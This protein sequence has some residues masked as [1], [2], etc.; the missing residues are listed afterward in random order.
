MKQQATKKRECVLLIDENNT[1]RA[2]LAS[3][4]RTSGHLVLEANT[5]QEA[6]TILQKQEVKLVIWDDAGSKAKNASFLQEVKARQPGVDLI[7]TGYGSR[8]DSSLGVVP[9]AGV[10]N[11][12]GRR[13]ELALIWKTLEQLAQGTTLQEME[14]LLQQLSRGTVFLHQKKLSPPTD[15]KAKGGALLALAKEQEAQPEERLLQ[16]GSFAAAPQSGEAWRGDEEIQLT[17]IEFALWVVLLRHP[18][19]TVSH[20]KLAREAKAFLGNKNS[21]PCRWEAQEFT[22]HYVRKLRKKLEP[23]PSNPRFILSIHG[24]GYRLALPPSSP[25][26]S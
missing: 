24:R 7:I 2:S 13:C 14:Q 5:P 19:Q 26:P 17:P 1:F 3:C 22:R 16:V 4:L 23:T 11:C 6:L 9:V 20:K 25:A 18:G 8:R 10:G 12:L 15:R 21:Q